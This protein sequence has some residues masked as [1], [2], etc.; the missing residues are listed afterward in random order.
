[1][2]RSLPALAPLV[3]LLWSGVMAAP[4]HEIDPSASPVPPGVTLTAP[5]AEAAEPVSEPAEIAP[6]TAPPR[7]VPA[8][9]L[10]F[11]AVVTASTAHVRGGPSTNH[12]PLARLDRGTEVKVLKQMFGW[13]QIEP[14]KGVFCW[15]HKDF[16]TL[17]ADGKSGT[18]TGQNVNVRGDSILGHD[19]LR[20]DVVT[21]VSAGAA[22]T[23]VGAAGDFLRIGP[24]AG[25]KV[26]IH[27]DLVVPKDATAVA[28][29]LSGA[30]EPR[31]T[32]G[33][34]AAVPDSLNAAE[35]ALAAERLKDPR[36][37]DLDRLAALYREV[38][39]RN[40]SAYVKAVVESRLAYIDRLVQLRATLDT[41]DR[42]RQATEAALRAIEER[43]AA[44]EAALAA[45]PVETAYTASGLLQT[46]EL[47]D[48]RPRYKLVSP[49][50][51]QRILCVVE[52]DVDTLRALVDR[53]VGI[54]GQFRVTAEW[55]VKVLRV[56]GIEALAA[57]GAGTR[58]ALPPAPTD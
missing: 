9:A 13:Y 39:D 54:T 6:S 57:G 26:Y 24:P 42:G 53:R 45:R 20:S 51:P 37:W 38:L 21:Q 14:P 4:I 28:A 55:P 33:A 30:A 52:G 35:E 41:V 3:A 7:A 34:G 50:D 43:R 47:S 46:L 36:T 8:V 31:P 18:V 49:D 29:D 32:P 17:S 22:V 12:F 48:G 19:A 40:P 23:V 11:V 5:G 10:P 15:I 1:V 27:A 16:V 2:R 44:E 25:A 56:T 58:I